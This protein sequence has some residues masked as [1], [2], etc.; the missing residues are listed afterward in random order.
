MTDLLYILPELAL[1][2]GGLV[3]LMYAAFAGDKQSGVIN[4]LAA[5]FLAL[6]LILLIRQPEGPTLVFSDTLRV[7]SF[8]IY[9]KA[10]I[11]ISAIAALLMAPRYFEAEG[12]RAEYPVLVLFSVLGMSIM[13]S[14]HDL[15]S[16]YIGLELNSLAA[17][18][19]AS[20]ARTDGRA[21]EAG[22]KYF[23]LG[24][25]ASGMLLYG[26]S[27]LY[28]F[29][30]TTNFA[31]IADVF[32]HGDNLGLIFGLVFVLAGLGFKIS[33]VPFHMWTPDVYEGAPTPVA[34]FFASAPKV[35]ALALL[36]R[37]CMEALPDAVGSW[38][39]IIS[40][41]A[42]ASMVLGAI[43][44]IGQRNIKRLLAYSSIANVGFILVGLAA[45]GPAA[46]NEAGVS[47]VIIYLTVYVV[48][49][50]GSF[51]AVLQLRDA[52]GRMV[53]DI[54]SLAGL[55]KTRPGLATAIA[56][57]M[58][59]LAGIPPLFGFW[60]KYLVFQA[61]ISAGL[62]PLAV[63]GA[64]ASVIGAF[65]YL[66]V[67]KVMMFDAPADVSFPAVGGVAERGVIAVSAA[68][69]SLFGFI[70]LAPLS[71][72]AAWAAGALL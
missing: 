45:A 8:S 40:F 53:E 7:D 38:Q 63:I 30:G 34:A 13:V 1:I 48:M 33:A 44:A 10:L 72:V 68:Y 61:A 25:L 66:R 3:L 35:A 60:P 36:T 29:T 20:F 37:F 57:F 47:S 2:I 71:Q 21:S 5:L 23:V 59:S 32:T 19:L 28:G 56:I 11:Y 43:G 49:T 70:L 24:S 50:L 31:G 51:L 69:V 54:A 14:A 15:M 52:N 42:I 46:T 27:L 65:Y 22:L 67:I 9:A 64:L 12:Y 55:W 18:V 58:F 4:A 16:L 17:Y 26:S 39:Q 62:L 41:M 6:A